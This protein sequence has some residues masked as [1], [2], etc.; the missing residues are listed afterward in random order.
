MSSKMYGYTFPVP[1]CGTQTDTRG[2]GGSPRYAT[3]LIYISKSDLHLSGCC[4]L[5]LAFLEEH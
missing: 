2:G 1:S 3:A 4:Q 5:I